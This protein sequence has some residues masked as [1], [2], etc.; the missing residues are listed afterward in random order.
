MS[1]LDFISGRNISTILAG[2][3]DVNATT[4]DELISQ[5]KPSE[6][7][8]PKWIQDHIIMTTST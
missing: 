6:R 1:A 8:N 7:K 5:Y 4:L 3:A 2:V